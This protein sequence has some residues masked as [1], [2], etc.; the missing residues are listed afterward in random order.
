MVG[1]VLLIC[2]V[3]MFN[4]V[5]VILFVLM[6]LSYLLKIAVL[7]WVVVFCEFALVML[8]LRIV[9][10]GSCLLSIIVLFV[11]WVVLFV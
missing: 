1:C 3:V 5:V 11:V 7:G 2:V 9:Y 8:L 6:N 10:C 4:S